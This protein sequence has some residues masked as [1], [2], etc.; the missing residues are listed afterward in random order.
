MAQLTSNSASALNVPDFAVTFVLTADF[1]SSVR[2]RTGEDDLVA[3]RAGGVPARRTIPTEDDHARCDVVVDT[4]LVGGGADPVHVMWSMAHEMCHVLLGRMRS[5]VPG[6]ALS[7][8]HVPFDRD[9]GAIALDAYDEYRCDNFA[10]WVVSHGVRRSPGEAPA[11][12]YEFVGDTYADLLRAALDERAHTGW[13]DLVHA[14][15]QHETSL[16]HLV[17]TV[18]RE[19][20]EAL[21]LAAHAH[22]VAASAGAGSPLAGLPHRDAELYLRPA[23]DE[24]VERLSS[25]PLV[26]TLAEF[27]R[28][29]AL[30][31]AAGSAALRQLWERLGISSRWTSEGKVYIAVDEP[32]S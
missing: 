4:S 30:V 13:A 3:E 16:G 12:G 5:A 22:A 27:S 2:R 20:R 32:M 24:I 26:P 6:V 15:R 21:T 25:T 11:S 14:Y 9:A 18:Q 17:R 7:P 1:E 10:N 19:T 29:D 28:S 8:G 23:W 31:F